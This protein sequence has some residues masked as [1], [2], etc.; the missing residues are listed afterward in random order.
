[1]ATEKSVF[2]GIGLRCSLHSPSRAPTLLGRCDHF[3]VVYQ[4]W[5]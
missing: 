3:Y 4:S 2:V 5:Y 1:V